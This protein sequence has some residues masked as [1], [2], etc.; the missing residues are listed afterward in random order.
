M[1]ILYLN[2]TA[3]LGGAERVL[4]DVIASVRQLDA[5]S[6]VDGRHELHVMLMADGPLVAAAREAGADSVHVHA[7]PAALAAIG[8]SGGGLGRVAT[9]G[10]VALP[11]LLGC[12]RRLR[13]AIREIGPD[14][15][16]SNGVKTHVLSRL[17]VPP[18]S[19]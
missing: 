11:T 4:L 10:A 12:V 15:I 13:G 6:P 9:R 16:H 2:P 7:M 14:I 8:E 19:D 1:R 18:S 5:K 17:I 3:Q